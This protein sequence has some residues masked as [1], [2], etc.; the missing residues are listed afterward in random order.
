M[1]VNSFKNMNNVLSNSL[2]EMSSHE[3]GLNLSTGRD[4]L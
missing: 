4:E 3:R 2:R 1:N